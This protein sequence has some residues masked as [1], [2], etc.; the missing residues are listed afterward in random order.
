MFRGLI[1]PGHSVDRQTD[2][3]ASRGIARVVTRS[4]FA[5]FTLAAVHAMLLTLYG[6]ATETTDQVRMLVFTET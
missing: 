2:Y 5:N 3:N 4:K 6:L 1:F